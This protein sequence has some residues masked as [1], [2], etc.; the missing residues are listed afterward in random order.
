MAK[1]FTLKDIPPEDRPQEKLMAYGSKVLSNAELLALIIRTGTKEK[2]AVQVSQDLINQIGG[3]K[4]L[5]KISLKDLL[6]TDGIGNSKA[7]MIM[8]SIELSLRLNER[9]EKGEKLTSPEKI[10]AFAGEELKNLQKEIVRVVILDTKKQFISY[11]DV[12]I[13]TINMSLIHPREIFKSAIDN[14]A[15]TIV[16]MHNHPSG[17]PSPSKEDMEITKRLK[18]AGKIIGIEVLDHIIVGDYGYYSFLEHGNLWLK[19]MCKR[20][21][22]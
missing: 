10:I 7:A 14:M 5:N 4:N 11:R 20:K 8:A 9:K 6:N 22:I 21:Y 13:G 1:K 17:D 12:S 19:T 2:N 18:E 16:I 3:L 15:D